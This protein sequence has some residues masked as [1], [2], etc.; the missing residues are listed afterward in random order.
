MI[1]SVILV[2]CM[3]VL[4]TPVN[5]FSLGPNPEGELSIQ[6][7]AAASPDYIR[8]WVSAPSAH[9]IHIDRIS[10]IVPEQTFYVAVIVTGYGLNTST[11]T[12]LTGDLVLQNPDGSIQFDEKAMFSHRRKMGKQG[13][14]SFLMMDPAVDLVLE[15]GDQRGVFVVKAIVTDRVLGKTATGEYEIVLRSGQQAQSDGSDQIAQEVSTAADLDKLWLSFFSKG[16]ERY[17]IRIIWRESE[18][19]AGQKRSRPCFRS[20]A[21]SGIGATSSF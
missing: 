7:V 16:D 21:W 11:M 5:A 13:R 19:P 9:D 10:E 18:K 17:V 1:R 6:V 15:E 12:D 14:V 2:V 3:L 20:Y 8:E 4:L